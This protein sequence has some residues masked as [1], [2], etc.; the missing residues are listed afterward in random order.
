MKIKNTT[1]TQQTQ[2][3]SGAGGDILGVWMRYTKKSKRKIKQNKIQN[4]N[5]TET[6]TKTKQK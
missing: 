2:L 3:K 4:K 6:K 5:I 1:K